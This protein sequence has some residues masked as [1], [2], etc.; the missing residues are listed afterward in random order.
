MLFGPDGQDDGKLDLYVT[1]AV[2]S[3]ANTG[4]YRP[5]AAP[6]T[7][8]V[9]RYDGTTGA[10]LGTFVA[11][12]SG[13]LQFPDFMTFTETDPT[14][15]NYVGGNPISTPST[16]ITAS[17]GPAADTLIAI[18]PGLDVTT[19]VDRKHW[20]PQLSISVRPARRLNRRRESS[21]RVETRYPPIGD[22]ES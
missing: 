5:T 16:A 8:E 4:K 10:F 9:L 1:S 6:G 12:D 21:R 22:C 20:T 15:L 2:G 11:P 17:A 18:G 19:S 3:A 14:T 13:G 7:S